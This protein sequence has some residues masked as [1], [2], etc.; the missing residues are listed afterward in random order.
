MKIDIYRSHKTTSSLG[1]TYVAVPA[2]ST[3]PRE[4]QDT[5]APLSVFKTIDVEA[6][7]KRIAMGC[8]AVLA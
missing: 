1:R 5:L 2:G 3:V 4:A 8:R 6:T 7:S